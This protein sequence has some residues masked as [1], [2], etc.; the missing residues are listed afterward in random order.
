MKKTVWVVVVGVI[1][2]GVV[3]LLI[4]EQSVAGESGVEDQKEAADQ[5][6]VPQTSGLPSSS[7]SRR[8]DSDT[9]DSDEAVA[10]ST[11]E[12]SEPVQVLFGLDGKERNYPEFLQAIG[13]LTTDLSAADVAAL[14]EMLM[15]PNDRFPEKMRDIEIN[16]VKNDVLD[17]LLRQT[18]LPEG[19]GLQ[20]AEMAAD[21]SNDPVWRDY[22][23]QFME[24]FCERLTAEYMGGNRQNNLGQNDSMRM[25][26]NNDSAPNHSACQT[27]LEVVREA[28]FSALDERSE[29]IAGTALIGLELLSRSHE[30]FDRELIIEKAVEIASDELAS[31]STRLTAMR[32]SAQIS[33]GEQGTPNVEVVQTARALAQTGE[34]VLLRSA[35]IVTLGEVGSADDRELLESFTFAENKQIAD[36]AKLALNKMNSRN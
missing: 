23:V 8:V 21:S 14:R 7:E 28:M 4:R 17:K 5:K 27:E 32:L 20:M 22:C 29:T 34:T 3:L 9:S 10:S 15:F 31:S 19:L 13:M 1:V 6:T 12:L 35:A 33:N 24:P 2:F 18:E 30:E 16:A 36:A 26:E 11:A 25:G